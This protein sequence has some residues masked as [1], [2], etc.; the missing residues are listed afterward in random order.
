MGTFLASCHNNSQLLRV[1]VTSHQKVVSYI[2]DQC[3]LFPRVLNTPDEHGITRHFH[4]TVR[5][6]GQN[7]NV[8]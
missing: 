5:L 4:V 7:L 2:S 6:T 8:K 1:I 3:I